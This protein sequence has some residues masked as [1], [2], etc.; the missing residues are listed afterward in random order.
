M[1]PHEL[2]P[3]LIITGFGFAGWTEG[4]SVRVVVTALLP[5]DGT[6]R[7]LEPKPGMRPSFCKQEF[8]RFTLG[9]ERSGL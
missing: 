3:D 6:N 7:Y 5:A 8:S 1:R 2:V 4:E 9:Q